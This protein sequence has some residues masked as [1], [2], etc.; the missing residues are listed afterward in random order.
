MLKRLLNKIRTR[1]VESLQVTRGQSTF[2]T[3][4]EGQVSGDFCYTSK[5]VSRLVRWKTENNFQSSKPL[6]HYITQAILAI[7]TVYDGKALNV[8]EIGGAFGDTFLKVNSKIGDLINSWTIVETTCIVE[9]S[10]S[11]NKDKKL[12][13]QEEFNV[14]GIE[15]PD[16]IVIQGTLQ[17]I[18]NPIEFLSQITHNFTGHLYLA[19]T[20]L[21]VNV[22][23]PFL[24]NDVSN[25]LDHGPGNAP[26]NIENRQFIST[27]YHLPMKLIEQTL[28]G[29]EIFSFNE[30]DILT[31]EFDFGILKYQWKGY[32]VKF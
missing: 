23:E 16:L 1:K 22:E 5:E 6:D 31:R 12:S 2:K 4:E 29:E 19:R 9:E 17:Y 25:L 32:L 28:K 18:K 21:S 13:F 30:S 3:Y 7:M 27:V 15:A 20:P 14:E 10:F 24:S 26:K 8:I 11:M